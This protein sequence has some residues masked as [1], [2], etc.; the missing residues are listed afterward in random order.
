MLEN[1]VAILENIKKMDISSFQ[2][3]M[4]TKQGIILPILYALGWNIFDPNEVKPEYVIDGYRID[5]SLIIDRSNKIFIEVKK[6]NTDLNKYQE[7]LINYSFRENIKI[8]I[9]TNGITW[10][11]YLPSKLEI[12]W[13]Q[14]KFLSIDINTQDLNIIAK[15]FIDLLFKENVQNGKSFQIANQIIDDKNR[16]KIIVETL[17]KA[18]NILLQEK[19]P[20]LIDLIIEKTEKLCGFKPSEDEVLDFI[21]DYLN[22]LSI[23]EINPLPSPHPEY[24]IDNPPN[25]I[26]EDTLIPLIVFFIGNQG[27]RSTK[28]EIEEKIYQ[29]YKFEFSKPYWQNSVAQ[30]TPRWK[31]YIAWAKQRAVSIHHYIKKPTDN[32]RGIWELTE[33]GNVYYQELKRKY[34]LTKSL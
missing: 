4:S 8:S 20:R 24:A 9:L 25:E 6:H 10:W 29:Y 30:G 15:N 27:G 21:S 34:E 22:R 28:K 3:E 18:W 19:E 11:F 12:N 26:K 2:D 32:S 14:R 16:L 7:Q 5:Y 13:K 1:L 17:P 23:P 33:K 31:H